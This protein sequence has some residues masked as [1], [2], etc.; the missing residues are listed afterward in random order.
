MQQQLCGGWWWIFFPWIGKRPIAEIKAPE[1]LT[2]LRRVEAGGDGGGTPDQ[3]HFRAGFRYGV[4]T[5][6]CERDPAGDLRE[7]LPQHG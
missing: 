7:A 5:G 6:R 4:S 1:L 3:D 2:V